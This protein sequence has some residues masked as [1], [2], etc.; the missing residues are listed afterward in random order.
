MIG[1]GLISFAFGVALATRYQFLILGVVTF[2]GLV[3][4]AAFAHVA[5]LPA[6][7]GVLAGLLFAISLQVGYLAGTLI[8]DVCAPLVRAPVRMQRRSR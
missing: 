2:A 4:I 5:A 7:S 3:A 1:L 8:F 6:M